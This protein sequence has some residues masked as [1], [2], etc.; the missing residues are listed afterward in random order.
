MPYRLPIS[1]C[2]QTISTLV[3]MISKKM[4]TLT[5]YRKTFSRSSLPFRTFVLRFA[6][7]YPSL[8]FYGWVSEGLRFM[9]ALVC[10]LIR[11]SVRYPILLTFLD[12][13]KLVYLFSSMRVRAYNFKYL[14]LLM[15]LLVSCVVDLWLP[16]RHLTTG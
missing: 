11:S 15:L 3:Q 1:T 14:T 12:K 5:S 13:Y 2:A 10:H 8:L 6:F 7:F 16:L 4:V 9:F